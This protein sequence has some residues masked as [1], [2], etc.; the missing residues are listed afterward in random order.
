MESLL[1]EQCHKHRRQCNPPPVEASFW[2]EQ[3]GGLRGGSAGNT[4]SLAA[5]ITLFLHSQSSLELIAKFFFFYVVYSKYTRFAKKEHTK[6][7]IIQ[8]KQHNTHVRKTF[9]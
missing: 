9:S 6:T 7:S 3:R 2:R 8:I 4:E 5:V 1:Q